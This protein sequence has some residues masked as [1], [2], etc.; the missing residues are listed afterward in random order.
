MAKI[1][2]YPALA[3]LDPAGLIP[4]VSGGSTR[5]I[6]PNQIRSWIDVRDH[7]A[8]GDGSTDDSAAIQA[9]LEAVPAAGGMIVVP[10]G[11]YKAKDLVYE[12]AGPLTIMG[13]AA[14]AS[15]ISTSGAVFLLPSAGPVLT[16][17]RSD[18]TNHYGIR[19]A[20]LAFNGGDLANAVAVKTL[21]RNFCL[22]ENISANLFSGANSIGF[23]FDGTGDAT[24]TNT[25]LHCKAR[26]C[27]TAVKAQQSTG[28]NIFSGFF[29]GGGIGIDHVSGDTLCVLGANFDAFT[30]VAVQVDTVGARI[31]AGRFEANQLAV[32]LK[33]GADRASVVGNFMIGF[34]A[35]TTGGV[36]ILSGASDGMLAGNTYSNMGGGFK[37]SNAGTNMSI[38][39]EPQFRV[40]FATGRITAGRQFEGSLQAKSEAGFAYVLLDSI[41]AGG[42]QWRLRS[43]TDGWCDFRNE[44]DGIT[45]F[46]INPT[47]NPVLRT[48][49]V[50]TLPSASANSGALIRISDEAGGAT[51][52][53][54]DGSAWRRVQD[55]AVA[56]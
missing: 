22:F 43:R 26:A 50:A 3:E 38:L 48:F 17:G 29:F 45:G 34:G 30:D 40:D 6:T 31:M 36:E 19:L 25:L 41:N 23:E 39:D 33:G 15:A 55:L 5:T 9:T 32:R 11:V 28:L 54:S 44:T 53:F 52:A 51:V 2:S 12:G 16:L 7:G 4:I 8:T 56:S 14:G 13:L 10:P 27:A 37:V 1:S 21:R 24:I 47:G 35:G 42:K 18:V 20:N 49:T 46:A